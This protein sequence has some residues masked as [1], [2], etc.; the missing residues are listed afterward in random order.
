MIEKSKLEAV[1]KVMGDAF[2]VTPTLDGIRIVPV[3]EAR[4]GQA[5]NEMEMSKLREVREALGERVSIYIKPELECDRETWWK[6]MHGAYAVI[7][8][9]RRIMGARFEVDP[10][11]GGLVLIFDDAGRMVDDVASEYAA[12]VAEARKLLDHRLSIRVSVR[13]AQ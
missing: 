4:H 2:T 9:I 3:E 1:R 6:T 7:T 8:A 11:P 10:L 5:L 12:Q 13:G